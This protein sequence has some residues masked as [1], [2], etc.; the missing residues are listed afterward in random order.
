[1]TVGKRASQRLRHSLNKPKVVLFVVLQSVENSSEVAAWFCRVDPP[2]VKFLTPSSTQL[3][4]RVI[5]ASFTSHFKLGFERTLNSVNVAI[6]FF[7]LQVCLKL[8]VIPVSLC[9]T[10]TKNK[11]VSINGKFLHANL[12]A[13]PGPKNY[14]ALEMVMTHTGFE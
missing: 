12:L 13:S 4:Y 9:G 8:P 10:L 5:I 1:M 14:T 11:P 2:A 3:Q 6:F 7:K